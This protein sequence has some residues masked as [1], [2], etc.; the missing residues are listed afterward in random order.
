LLENWQSFIRDKYHFFTYF[1]RWQ[2]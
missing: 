1:I 2:E